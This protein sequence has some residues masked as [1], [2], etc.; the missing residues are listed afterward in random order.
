M[1]RLRRL[2]ILVAVVDGGSFARAARQLLIT[3]SAVSH[4]MTQLEQEL[5]I[6]LLY[7]TTRQL[8]LSPEGQEVLEQAR[9]VLADFAQLD[10]LVLGQRHGVSGTLRLAVP[11][12]VAH[13][14]LMPALPDFC[15]RHPQL[16]I[17]LVSV[18]PDATV[19]SSGADLGFRIGP[20]LDSELVARPLGHLHFG[21][22]ASPQYLKRHGVPQHPQDLLSHRTLVHKPP[23][24]PGISPWDQWSYERADERGVVQVPHHLVTDDREALLEAAL[25]GAGLFRIGLFPPQWIH[26]GRLVPVLTPW[27]WT[28]APELTML[29]R[30][31]RP[32]P[33]RVSAFIE[34]AEATLAAFDP[35][36]MTLRVR[37]RR[38]G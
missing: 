32:L 12:A 6:T 9:T 34:F 16:R 8:R 27:A 38:P 37:A 4:A 31:A 7:R 36:G 3:P 23:R 15:A 33:R 14:V 2:E 17:E 28:G 29:Y 35:Q 5:G 13:H 20:V 21:V 30:K 24:S 10:A 1:D 19:Q 18:G 22:Y 26:S 11:P 25:A